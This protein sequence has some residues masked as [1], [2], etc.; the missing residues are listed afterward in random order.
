MQ[1]QP[2]AP[3]PHPH[4][5]AT[6]LARCT[7]V[8]KEWRAQLAADG[9][10]TG[11]SI[12]RAAVAASTDGTQKFLLQVRWCPQVAGPAFLARF[13]GFLIGYYISFVR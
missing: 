7:A 5:P 4:W 1:P 11:R 12:L 13:S 10:R 3:L 9:V 2:R 8:P 6:A